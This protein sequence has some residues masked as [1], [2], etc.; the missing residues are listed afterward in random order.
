MAYFFLQ[1]VDETCR[2][3]FPASAAEAKT[4]RCPRCRGPVVV[5]AE[6]SHERPL[7]GDTPGDVR[8]LVGLLDNIRSIHNTGSMFR[9]ADGA[10][11]GHLYLAGITATP[12]HSRLAKAALG[13]HVVVS[14]S[15]GPNAVEMAAALR[16][17]GYRLWALEPRTPSSPAGVTVKE[18]PARLALVVGNERAGVD[19]GVM[20]LCEGVLSLPMTGQKTSLNA[21]V[22]F[23]IAVY[24]LQFGAAHPVVHP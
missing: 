7:H 10:G 12:D 23:G 2:F 6:A 4:A 17:D 21:A 8:A 11:V 18:R 15:Y 3:R 24:Y 19:P 20:A 14:W 9:T 1:C 13:A 16:S 22:A 5:A